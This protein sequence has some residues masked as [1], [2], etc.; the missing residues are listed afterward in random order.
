MSEMIRTW[1]VPASDGEPE[2]SFP[3]R[4]P[5]WTGD[6]LGLKTWGTAFAL[7]KILAKIGHKHFR[8][9]VKPRNVNYTTAGGSTFAQP[10]NQRVLE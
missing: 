3:I 5:S 9:V 2:F 7:A 10:S 8:H 1:V 6:N 4:E